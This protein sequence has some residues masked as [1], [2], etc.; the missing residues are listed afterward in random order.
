L[1]SFLGLPKSGILAGGTASD[2]NSYLK[3]AYL[4]D[5]KDSNLKTPACLKTLQQKKQMVPYKNFLS[6]KLEVLLLM[7]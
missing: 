4:T 3:I 6:L 5:P 7:V 1:V 2:A